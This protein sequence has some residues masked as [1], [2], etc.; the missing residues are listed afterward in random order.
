MFPQMNQ[1]LDCHSGESGSAE[2]AEG[3]NPGVVPEK[4]GNQILYPGP[5]LSPPDK[6]IPGQA[7]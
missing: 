6:D 5:W 1:P 4:A 7:W 3:R 2:L